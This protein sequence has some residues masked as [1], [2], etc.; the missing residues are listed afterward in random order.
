MMQIAGG[1]G[2]HPTL[3]FVVGAFRLTTKL[4]VSAD[5]GLPQ[6]PCAACQLQ[7][8]TIS[9]WEKVRA[10]AKLKVDRTI[11]RMD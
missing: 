2:H 5:R 6:N 10:K 3:G 4:C 9:V 7:Y 11:D 8:N 1:K